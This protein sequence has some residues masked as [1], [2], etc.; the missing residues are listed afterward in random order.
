MSKMKQTLEIEQAL[1]K[2]TSDLLGCY[3]RLRLRSGVQVQAVTNA[4]TMLNLIR[5][6]KS[7][8]MRSK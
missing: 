2:R 3:E 5:L 8:A 6:V 1:I 7:N 4:A